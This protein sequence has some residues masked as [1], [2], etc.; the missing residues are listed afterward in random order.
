MSYLFR[1]FALCA[2]DGCALVQGGEAGGE[3]AQQDAVGGQEEKAADGDFP[4]VVHQGDFLPVCRHVGIGAAVEGDTEEGDSVDGVADDGGGG[5]RHPPQTHLPQAVE[6]GDVQQL[7]DEVGGEAGDDDAANEAVV[8][9]ERCEAGVGAVVEKDGDEVG[10]RERR[11]GRIEDDAPCEGG[12][13]DA[14]G[15]VGSKEDEGVGE[16]APGGFQA[17]DFKGQLHE[18]VAGD[19]D[20]V[21]PEG[22]PDKGVMALGGGE[23]IGGVVHM[24]FRWGGENGGGFWDARSR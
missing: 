18:V 22:K 15:E 14:H 10:K 6:D 21:V 4:A 19:D 1:L 20:D 3:V 11:H 16:G 9:G 12:T 8:S 5:R 24:G 17:E 13:E 23:G 2:G 7:A